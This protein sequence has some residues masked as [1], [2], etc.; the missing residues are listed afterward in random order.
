MEVKDS[1]DLTGH[2]A[3][4]IMVNANTAPIASITI[5]PLY[6]STETVFTFDASNS[7]DHEDSASDL[8][9]RWDWDNDGSWDTEYSNLKTLTHQYDTEGI[10]TI[11][12]VPF[13]DL[14][15]SLTR[16]LSAFAFNRIAFIFSNPAEILVSY[17]DNISYFN[18][19]AFSFP[20]SPSYS[21]SNLDMRFK[22]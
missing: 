10:K 14:R 17:S 16:S 1:G 6:G 18:F 11:Q 13:L 21:F 9:V 8:L 12:D 20:N 3:R 2:I 15:N 22:R 4:D 5:N 19:L 7:S